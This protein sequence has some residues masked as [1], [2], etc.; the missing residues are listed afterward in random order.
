MMT[1]YGRIDS[2]TEDMA[3]MGNEIRINTLNTVKRLDT[4]ITNA[5]GI[6]VMGVGAVKLPAPGVLEKDIEDINGFDPRDDYGMNT[7]QERFTEAEIA[8]CGTGKTGSSLT[9][10]VSN[11]HGILRRNLCMAKMRLEAE[12]L[13]RNALHA[14]KLTEY[15]VALRALANASSSTPGQL[16]SRELAA[17]NLEALQE[18]E[19]S[20]HRNFTRMHGQQMEIVTS[21]LRTVEQE[22]LSGAPP[23]VTGFSSTAKRTAVKY[24]IGNVLGSTTRGVNGDDGGF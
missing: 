16:A 11:E 23:T 2:G 7:M 18:N 8:A 1:L 6:A 13:N 19:I 17:L 20:R 3:E 14:A 15:R 5:K 4:Q 12:E 10:P 24:I 22:A 21:R 9:A